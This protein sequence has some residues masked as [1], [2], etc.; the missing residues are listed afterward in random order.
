MK[1]SL[2]PSLVALFGS[3]TRVAVLAVLAGASRPLTGYR[4][5]KIAGVQPIKAYG[6]LRRLQGARVVR[7]LPSGWQLLDPQVRRFVGNRVR[8]AWSEDWEAGVRERARRAEKVLAGSRRWFDP[9][10]YQPNP[11]VAVRYSREIDRPPEKGPSR[12]T[13]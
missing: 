5:A 8:V 4:V 2:D 3:E 10:R 9:S 6:E 7:K 13:R 11:S 12:K 1:I